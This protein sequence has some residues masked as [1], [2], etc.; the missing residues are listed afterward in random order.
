MS[1]LS[2]HYLPNLY[3]FRQLL[4]EDC[5]IDTHEHFLKQTYRNRCT[6][7]TANGPLNLTIPVHKKQHMPVV[8]IRIDNSFRWQ[9]QHWDAIVSAYNS[10]PYFLYFRHHFEKLYHTQY[11]YL[12]DFNTDILLI[13]LMLLQVENK[14]NFSSAYLESPANDLRE[15][16]HPKKQIDFVW[17][18]YPQV[19]SEKFNFYPNL[20]IL[21][22][23]MMQGKEAV[24]YL[25]S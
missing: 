4:T 2:L 8:D 7:L 20:S 23:L 19:F 15:M 1:I 13:C 21:D 9:K 16:I 24:D 10:S 22:I 17:K 5:I 6:I 11:T 3:W 14:L 18:A 25:K 12:K